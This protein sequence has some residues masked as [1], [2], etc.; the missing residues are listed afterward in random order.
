MLWFQIRSKKWNSSGFNRL[1]DHPCAV[2]IFELSVKGGGIAM[3]LKTIVLSIT[4]AL[5]VALGVGGCE[6]EGP[7]EKAGKE[8]DKTVEKAGE[9]ID[10]AMEKTGEKVEEAGDKVKDAT[11]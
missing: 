9:K 3:K 8:I 5:I 6:K 1:E 4:F 7:A 11:K 2:T 10:K